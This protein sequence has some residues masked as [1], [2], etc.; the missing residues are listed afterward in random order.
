M[1][2]AGGAWLWA[3]L[4]AGTEPRE[5]SGSAGR[6][7]S[8]RGRGGRTGAGLGPPRIVPR[9]AG[10][11]GP[12]PV[13]FPGMVSKGLLRLVSSV[14]RRRMKLLLAIALL[15]YAACE[16]TRGG[17][18]PIHSRAAAGSR[19][20][21][22]VAG[23]VGPGAESPA[24]TRLNLYSGAAAAMLAAR[25]RVGPVSDLVAG[26]GAFAPDAVVMFPES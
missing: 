8:A 14:N 6:K 3:G 26:G 2:E 18:E 5:R 16:C 9:L 7:R 22:R 4:E 15:A 25:L 1:E 21:G 23:C 13:R 17:R 12:G 11:A 19:L 20:C 10:A 24:Y